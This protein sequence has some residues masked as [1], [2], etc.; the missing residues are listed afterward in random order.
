MLVVGFAVCFGYLGCGQYCLPMGFL[1]LLLLG[2]GC[3]VC[4]GFGVD[5][6]CALGLL[7]G[8]LLHRFLM[9]LGRFCVLLNLWFAYF[10]LCLCVMLLRLCW[11]LAVFELLVRIAVGLFWGWLA[12]LLGG[13]GG[14]WISGFDG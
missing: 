6:V 14:D 10:V 5:C 13:L 4:C 8:C 11:A 3:W 12:G 2:F 9:L 7:C 1:W